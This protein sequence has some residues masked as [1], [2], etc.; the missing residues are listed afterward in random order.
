MDHTDLS[1]NG[2]PFSAY[3]GQFDMGNRDEALDGMAYVQT[4]WNFRGQ[5][6]VFSSVQQKGSTSTHLV[7]N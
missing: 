7:S 6:E 5:A 2:G 1:E 3:P 4:Q